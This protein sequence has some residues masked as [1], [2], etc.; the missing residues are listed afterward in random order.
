MSWDVWLMRVP[1]EIVSIHDLP[2]DFVSELG[3]QAEIL[4]RLVEIFPELDMS[5]PGWGFME[6]ADFFIDFNIGKDDPIETIALHVRGGDG[7]LGPIHK[8]CQATGWRAFDT[9]AGEF[10][11]FERSPAA[12]LQ[13]W[14]ASRDR[15]V[16]ALE[17]QEA[18]EAKTAKKWW[19]FW[20]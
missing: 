14:R 2:K 1:P 3:S 11:D 5:T 18:G 4:P 15:V 17:A 20:K 7:A 19:Q 6:G 8:L 10:I 9:T 13:T 16:A 12:G